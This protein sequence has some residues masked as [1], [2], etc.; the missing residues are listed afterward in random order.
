MP[1]SGPVQGE[2]VMGGCEPAAQTDR[3]GHVEVPASRAHLGIASWVSVGT[4]GYID[5]CCIDP[6]IP[7]YPVPCPRPAYPQPVPP[8]T[9]VPS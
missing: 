9:P 7:T 3:T 1:G 6:S 2:A 4:E 8:P 5:R